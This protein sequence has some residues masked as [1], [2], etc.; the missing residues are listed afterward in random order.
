MCDLDTVFEA[1]A[2]ERRRIAIRCL[3]EHH[4]ITLPDL[5]ELVAEHEH[6]CDLRAIPDEQVR[7][8]YVALYHRH[9]PLLEEADF[10]TYCQEEDL[11][12]G[13]IERPPMLDSAEETMQSLL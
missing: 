11:V 9:I 12:L 1:L 10:L 13:T 5:A 7:D 4:E 2:D 8:T 3:R 6:D